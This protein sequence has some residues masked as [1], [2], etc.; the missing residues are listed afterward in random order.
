MLACN[1]SQLTLFTVPSPL[2]LQEGLT[3]G[4]CLQKGGRGPALF[5]FLGGVGFFQ[6]GAEGRLKVIFNC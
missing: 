3:N 1:M 2:F 6:V 4:Q 5:E